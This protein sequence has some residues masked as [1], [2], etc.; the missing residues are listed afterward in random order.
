VGV[1][2]GIM[3]VDVSDGSVNWSVSASST[4]RLT[5]ANGVLYS[6]GRSVEARNPATGQLIWSSTFGTGVS[7]G[8]AVG[9]DRL[10]IGTGDSQFRALDASTGTQV[11]GYPLADP[12]FGWP[13]L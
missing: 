9:G 6:V 12:M 2:G 3:S 1:N 10:Y 11:W 13:A 4:D 5:Y 7:S 8:L